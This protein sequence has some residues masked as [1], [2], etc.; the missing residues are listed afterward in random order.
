MN[1][2][3]KNLVD[4]IPL[5]YRPFLF[6]LLND[7][8][9][10]LLIEGSRS[11]GK[12]TFM[13]DKLVLIYAVL[14]QE[15]DIVIMGKY[16]NGHSKTKAKIE[17]VFKE[18]SKMFPMLAEFEFKEYDGIEVYERLGDDGQPQRIH[19]GF[20]KNKGVEKMKSLN[21]FVAKY[22]SLWV[23]DEAEDNNGDTDDIT[24]EENRQIIDDLDITF[25]RR[26]LPKYKD[27]NKYPKTKLYAGYNPKVENGAFEDDF[28]TLIPDINEL[29]TKGYQYQIKPQYNGG[30]GVVLVRNNMYGL[31]LDPNKDFWPVQTDIDR[32]LYVKKVNPRLYLT[33]FLGIRITPSDN[34]IKRYENLLIT[35]YDS[36]LMPVRVG[37]DQG[38]VDNSTL[39]VRARIPKINSSGDIVGLVKETGILSAPIDELIIKGI[40]SNSTINQQDLLTTSVAKKFAD[41]IIE[42]ST[43]NPKYVKYYINNGFDICY[44]E[45]DHWLISKIQKILDKTAYGRMYR[46]VKITD[47]KHKYAIEQRYTLRQNAIRD[48]KE[49]L[50]RDFTPQL[51][52]ALMSMN[53]RNWKLDRNRNIDIVDADFYAGY[54]DYVEI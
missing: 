28:D 12:S 41:K 4:L 52:K 25:S 8:V 7:I 46:Y 27:L 14:Y 30:N 16:K 10:W 5:S 45:N 44:G 3:T 33:D 39:I 50:S 22:I 38:L 51:H 35:D 13:Y 37:I 40:K 32:M 24:K 17:K 29:E 31:I 21:M 15:G 43:D 11:S 54:E 1:K 2:K 36:K 20:I 53:K 26:D 9:A 47:A 6:L 23:L 49:F 19:F 42:V 18:N 34:L 48:G